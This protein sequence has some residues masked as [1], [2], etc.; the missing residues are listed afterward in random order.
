MIFLDNL[1]FAN[2]TWCKEFI[3]RRDFNALMLQQNDNVTIQ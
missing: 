2:D 1:E 3:G